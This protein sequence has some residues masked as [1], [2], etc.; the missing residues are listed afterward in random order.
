MFDLIVTY[1]PEKVPEINRKPEKT[2]E[3]LYGNFYLF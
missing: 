3:V 2:I 1:V